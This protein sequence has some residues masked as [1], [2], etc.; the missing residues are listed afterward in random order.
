MDSCW[1]FVACLSADL[2][3]SGKKEASGEKL[4][5]CRNK[6]YF[7]QLLP[8][9]LVWKSEEVNM[10][11]KI[12]A[13][14]FLHIMLLVAIHPV[15]AMHFCGGRL[16]SVNFFIPEVNHPCCQIAE[17]IVIEEENPAC[18]GA[19]EP[20]AAADFESCIAE[21]ELEQADDA[22]CAFQI[23]ELS[24]DDYQVQTQK[25]SY[26]PVWYSFESSWFTVNNRFALNEP[27]P[28]LSIPENEFPPGG[29]FMQDVSL[30]TYICIYRL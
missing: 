8:K 2:S 14:F 23:V 28:D 26:N 19:E 29:L 1:F 7:C 22:C 30:L 5:H 17:D 9:I 3:F 21:P 13:L 12:I 10:R 27:E 20:A 18:C 11:K 6:N 24:T 15:V 4:V 16:H 25:A